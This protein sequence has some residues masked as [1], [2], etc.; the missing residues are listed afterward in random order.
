[1]DEISTLGC[2]VY[3]IYAPAPEHVPSENTV[4]SKDAEWEGTRGVESC[5]CVGTFEETG[6]TWWVVSDVFSVYAPTPDP[7]SSQNADWEEGTGAESCTCVGA[8]KKDS[9]TW[10]IACDVLSIYT[11]TPAPE[12][13]KS[14]NPIIVQPR[15]R[16]G[17]VGI[18]SCDNQWYCRNI[19]VLEA[20]GW[21]GWDWVGVAF[22]FSGAVP[23][24]RVDGCGWGEEGA[25]VGVG[26]K[27]ERKWFGVE[28]DGECG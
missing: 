10:W 24:R 9:G 18:T 7:G 15:A 22:A 26:W 12:E 11:P 2:H 13:P 19:S 14:E 28:E 17:C 25:G 23:G 3:A 27:W 5:A 4:P 6:G 21:W 20:V 1:L 8:L 16:Y